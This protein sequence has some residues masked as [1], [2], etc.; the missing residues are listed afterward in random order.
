VLDRVV[1]GGREG[2]VGV[3]VRVFE[4]GEEKVLG[5]KDTGNL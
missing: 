1:F 4:W 3:L 2:L 5:I